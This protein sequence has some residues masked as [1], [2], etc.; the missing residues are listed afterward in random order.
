M[1]D[2]VLLLVADSLRRD[3]LTTSRIHTPS[4]DRL[5]SEG[6]AF[7][8]ARSPGPGTPVSM[9]SI[10][11]GSF[12]FTHGYI[13][14]TA[15]HPVIS[16]KLSNNGF[17]TAGFHSNGWCD[18]D[19]GY[20]RG[21]DMLED[22]DVDRSE[23]PL[24]NPSR[25]LI[26]ELS[27]GF[28]NFPNLTKLRRTQLMELLTR[29]VV[30]GLSKIVP[31]AKNDITAD[32]S[33]VHNRMIEWVDESTTPRFGWAQYMDTHFPYMAPNS[34]FDHSNQM[35]LNYRMTRNR[36]A[37]RAI[38]PEDQRSI[39]ELYR[40]EIRYLDSELERLLSELEER[41]ELSKTLIIFTADHGELLGEYGKFA[42]KSARLDSP[43]T[44]VPLIMWADNLPDRTIHQPVSLVDIVP[45]IY[46]Y[47]N[48]DIPSSIDGHS[49]RPVIDQN[50]SPE[51]P[52][53]SEIGHDPMNF[54]GLPSK[55]TTVVTIE[56][57]DRLV[58]AD[59]LNGDIPNTESEELDILRN[60]RS[61]VQEDHS[62]DVNKH[63]QDS[64]TKKR[65]KDLGYLE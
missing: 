57:E 12:P 52:A 32:A 8:R 25:W 21:F 31:D 37:D 43:L 14:I 16:S 27:S 59:W 26:R 63:T 1:F 44:E 5:G 38:D 13:E 45:T 19:H 58:T 22:I 55:K 46:D 36:V 51:T 54:E 35:K 23:G 30:D 17:S 56:T 40:E 29:S 28:P 39:L 4:I 3:F 10:L 15:D 48:I 49:L 60:R 53:I 34:D 2:N 18:A 62:S 24:I 33:E 50:K 64:T 9:P 61:V 65:L 47:L 6:V 42:H 11:S 41:N 20:D 7:T